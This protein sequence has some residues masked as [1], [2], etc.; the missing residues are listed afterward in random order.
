MKKL[1][2]TGILAFA[3]GTGFLGCASM[4]PTQKGAVG[5][6]A[7]GAGIGAITGDEDDALIGA[8]IGALG[9]AILGHEIGH[10]R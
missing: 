4:N 5:G 1:L 2:C 7:V 9:G 10:H 6:A 3:L 8:G